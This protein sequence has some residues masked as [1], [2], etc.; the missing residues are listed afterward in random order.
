M[1]FSDY[2][3]FGPAYFEGSA[4]GETHPAGYSAYSRDRTD[5]DAAA[6]EVADLLADHGLDPSTSSVVILGCAYG[7]TVASLV[8]NHGVDATGLEI[9]TWASECGARLSGHPSRV[10]NGSA[11]KT[12]D[13]PKADAIISVRLASCLTD[14][15]AS[16][17]ATIADDRADVFSA[18]Y[19]SDTAYLDSDW[20]NARDAS[21]WSAM[22][23][24]E[25]FHASR[26]TEG[27]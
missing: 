12:G 23:P 3:E 11:L 21:E 2:G 5:P 16:T 8:E 25:W 6:A 9:S 13:V 17:M 15:E 10:V 14:E 19:V 22:V 4:V 1:A 7:F 27:E 26:L 20:Y 24:G 18:H